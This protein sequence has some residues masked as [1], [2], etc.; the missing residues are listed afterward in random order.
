MFTLYDQFLRD[1]LFRNIP[2]VYSITQV[3][4]QLTFRAFAAVVVA[5]GLVLL[6]GKPVIAWLRR[7]KIGDTGVT[8]AAALSATAGSKKHVPT[9]GGLLIVGAILFTV[10]LVGNLSNF[11]VV[12]AIITMVWLAVLGG[13]DD[14]LKLT[15]AARG[16]GRQGLH[17]WE[18]LVFQLGLGLLVAYFTYNHGNADA[19]KVSLSHVLNLPFQKTYESSLGVINEGLVF[20]PQALFIVI[21]V[22]IVAGMSNA[23]NITD[24]MDGLAT[25]VSAAVGLGLLVLAYV[26]GVESVAK[27]LLVPYIPGSEEL[28]VVAGAMAGACLGFLWFNCS[29]ASVFMGDTG[30]LAL[31]GLIGFIAL[32]V[33]QEI[34]VLFMCGI[35]LSEIGSVMLQVGYFKAT[36]GKRVFRCAPYHHHLHLGGWTE[37]QVVS[38]AWIVAVLLV[39][40]ALAS[41]KM[42]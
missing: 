24:G 39:V 35:F 16:G 3:L 30:S 33:R 18:K 36:G 40:L 11:Y 22:L 17:A 1:W 19:G 38:R 32:V 34:L 13:F 25:G 41:I 31:G 21:G 37:G 28:A 10:G 6:L 9:M 12:L 29:P 8:D 4:D 2:G 7:K 23:V 5:F 14:W 26:A 42:R 27:L 20:L 15:A